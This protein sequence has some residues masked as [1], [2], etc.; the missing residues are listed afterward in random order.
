MTGNAAS[1]QVCQQIFI[2]RS[3]TDLHQNSTSGQEG[4]HATKPSDYQFEISIDF[5][6]EKQQ[7]SST[8]LPEKQSI[9][10]RPFD[11]SYVSVL[12]ER[13]SAAVSAKFVKRRKL[14]STLN[15]SRNAEPHAVVTVLKR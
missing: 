15:G 5:G 6:T 13:D 14:R 2:T 12:P 1:I 11:E 7:R 3:R 8:P 10:K 9:S 4:T